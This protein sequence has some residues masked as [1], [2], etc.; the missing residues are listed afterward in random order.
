[1]KLILMLLV[2]I[3]TLSIFNTPNYEGYYQWTGD[4]QS[5]SRQY[6]KIF[7]KL[8]Q[9]ILPRTTCDNCIYQWSPYHSEAG[10]DALEKVLKISRRDAA[11]VIIRSGITFDEFIKAI[12]QHGTNN[13]LSNMWKHSKE[14]PCTEQEIINL[15]AWCKCH[16]PFYWSSHDGETL[17]WLASNILKRNINDEELITISRK[18]ENIFVTSRVLG[19]LASGTITLK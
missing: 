15:M 8:H 10:I 17:R 14:F 4:V 18:Y 9:P 13:K 12:Y 16:H 2:I 19:E 5:R 6:P 7:G 3:L 11:C 1:M